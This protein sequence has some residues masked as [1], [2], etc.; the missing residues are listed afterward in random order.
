MVEIFVGPDK[1][2][3]R[4]YKKVL[5]DKIDYF[6]K[7]FNR[8]FKEAN[9]GK[10]TLPEEKLKSFDLLLGWVY[11]GIIRPLTFACKGTRSRYSWCPI[12]FYSLA[13]KLCLPNLQDWI[14]STLIE[15]DDTENTLE[16]GYHAS[17]VYQVT[18]P[19]SPLRKYVSQ[20]MA[21]LLL[22]KPDCPTSAFF[23]SLE[24]NDLAQDFMDNLRGMSSKK[25]PD[26]R[27]L[28]KCDFHCHERG[29]DC[30][31]EV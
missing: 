8:S 14:M 15:T 30:P 31:D 20:G 19:N 29:A 12:K 22:N 21:Y 10:V 24:N 28:P 6:D 2:L 11:H 7:M 13:E 26:P 23:T 18:H 9:E 27:C 1:K 5:C 4:V 16:A 3:F 25:F 17:L